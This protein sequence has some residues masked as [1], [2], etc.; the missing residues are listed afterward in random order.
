MLLAAGKGERM[1]PLTLE[2]P[3]PLL[4]IAGKPLIEYHIEAL[5]AAGI[6]ELVINVSWLGEQIEAYCGDGA[7]WGCVIRYSREDTPLETAGGI[8]KALPLLGK[9][10]FLLVNADTWTDYAFENLARQPLTAAAARLV[11]VDNPAH[12]AAGDFSLQGER[13]GLASVNTLTYAGIGLYDPRF[14]D[15]YAAGKRA[16]LPL[17]QQAIAERRLFAEHFLG[18]WTDVGTPERLARLEQERIDYE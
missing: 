15:G 11:L 5:V 10:P 1:R 17:L 6:R 2:T 13:V 4:A 9:Q 8:I 3:K 7:R 18:R 16:L 12:N 14:F